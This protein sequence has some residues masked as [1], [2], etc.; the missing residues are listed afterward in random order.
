M[1]YIEVYD[2]WYDRRK[3]HSV[4]V[5][6]DDIEYAIVKEIADAL[7]VDMSEAIRRCIWTTRILFDPD[8]KLK[9]A[10]IDNPNPE[11]ALIDNL[12]PI[13]ELGYKIGI[14]LKYLRRTTTAIFR[15]NSEK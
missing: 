3:K 15:N 4:T 5:R 9:D 1:Y 13:P 2:M 10:L 12:R 14:E 6:L 7:K 8:L 11:Q